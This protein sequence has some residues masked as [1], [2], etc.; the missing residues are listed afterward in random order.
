MNKVSIPGLSPRYPYVHCNNA[1]S[2]CQVTAGEGEINAA[3]TGIIVRNYS[4]S[5]TL[6]ILSVYIVASSL[7]MSSS[8]DLTNTYF[9]VAGIA[10]G[11]P[12]YTT[13]GGATYSKYVVQVDLQY[14]LDAR[15]I[16]SGWST[17]YWEYGS[18]APST[19]DSLAHF[20]SAVSGNLYGSE[21]FELNEAL[22]AHVLN[23]TAN[24]KLYDTNESM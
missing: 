13:L 6:S 8:F 18:L 1:F 9:L 12:E 10:G 17:G 21:V 16:P 22:L 5:R 24:V 2:V 14:E 20:L 11:N 15:E 19:N 3:V 4:P 7:F 23:L